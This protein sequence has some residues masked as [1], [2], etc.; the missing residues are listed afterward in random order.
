MSLSPNAQL[1]YDIGEFF[2]AGFFEEETASNAKRFC[3]AYRRFYETC[4]LQIYIPGTPLYPNHKLEQA[5]LGVEPQYC[6]QY[7]YNRD[8]LQKKSRTA[9]E[10]FD[11]FDAEHGDFLSVEGLETVRSEVAEFD[12]WNHSALNFKRINAEGL[13]GYEDR[14]RAMKDEDLKD[15]LLDVL[16]GIRSYHRRALAYLISVGAEAR[17]IEAL[18]KVPFMPAENAYDA[19]VSANFMFCFDGCDNIGY[20][21]GWLP[22][23]W[24]GENLEDVMH[25]MMKALMDSAGWSITIGP[26]YSDLTKQWLRASRVLARPMV[27]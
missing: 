27:E 7:F 24:K 2:A 10:I 17:L 26:E 12:A 8:T 11:R 6:R 13:S 20:V 19:L 16:E 9:V 4:P 22:R 25:C 18:K 14:I 3:R 21:D 23:Y 1:F 5:G 15:A